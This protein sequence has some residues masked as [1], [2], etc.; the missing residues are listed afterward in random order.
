M[1]NAINTSKT[2]DS[3]VVLEINGFEIE[4]AV[5]FDWTP[6]ELP[7]RTDPGTAAEFYI[8]ALHS[9]DKP[10]TDL[11]ALLEFPEI[12]ENILEQI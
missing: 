3:V 8:T 1:K 6:A 10:P 9:T 7:T 5:S 4:C 2:G 11:S 12:E